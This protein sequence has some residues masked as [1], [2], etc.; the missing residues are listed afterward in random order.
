MSS[1][2]IHDDDNVEIVRRADQVNQE[3]L[4]TPTTEKKYSETDPNYIDISESLPSKFYF[5]PFNTLCVRTF[6]HQHISK[7]AIASEMDDIVGVLDTISSVMEPGKSA[8]DLTI[9][10][11]FFLMYWLRINSFKRSPYKIEYVCTNSEHRSK[12][13]LGQLERDT[14]LNEELVHKASQLDLIHADFTKANE[15]NTFIRE[16]YGVETLPKTMADFVGLQAFSTKIE[17]LKELFS[18]ST[19]DDEKDVYKE[20]IKQLQTQYHLHEYASFIHPTHGKTIQERISFL[21]E[22]DVD[23][24]FLSYLDDFI[25]AV[26]HGVKETAAVRCKECDAKMEVNISIDALHFFPELLRAKLA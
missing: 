16:T 1:I 9:G 20:Q 12:V 17:E 7:L 2:A 3:Q 23:A 5:Y 19:N 26:D 15:I 24:D 4:K 25:Q 13:V 10:D 11:F 8:Y 14:L 21:N 18:K 6:K 22:L